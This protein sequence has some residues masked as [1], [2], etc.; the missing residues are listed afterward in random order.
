[1]KFLL[2]SILLTVTGLG[3]Q[4]LT[5]TPLT[6]EDLAAERGVRYHSFEIKYPQTP[7][8][9][10]YDLVLYRDGKIDRILDGNSFRLKQSTRNPDRVVVMVGQPVDGETP[11]TLR[12]QHTASRMKVRFKADEEMMHWAGQPKLD[13]KNRVL[14]SFAPYDP[15]GP[16]ESIGAENS[17]PEGAYCALVLQITPEYPKEES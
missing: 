12:A 4:Q 3:A 2:F 14:L 11:I 13:E 17:T 15:M 7:E 6:A 1:M 8:Q 9:I 10:S 5:P 16:A